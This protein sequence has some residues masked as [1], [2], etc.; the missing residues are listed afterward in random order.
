M[1][2]AKYQQVLDIGASLNI[3]NGDLKEDHGQHIV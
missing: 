2:K 3:K 1:I